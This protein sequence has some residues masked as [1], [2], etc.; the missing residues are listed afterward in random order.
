[1]RVQPCC[2]TERAVVKKIP[3]HLGPPATGPPKAPARGAAQLELDER[4]ADDCWT[5]DQTTTRKGALARLR[6]WWAGARLRRCRAAWTG[7]VS[8]RYGIASPPEGVAARCG[9]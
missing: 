8:A 9:E 3:E 1:M 6:Y 7:V 2:L 5:S 4:P